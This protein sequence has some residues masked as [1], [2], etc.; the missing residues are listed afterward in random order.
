[1][2]IAS[3]IIGPIAGPVLGSAL[4]VSLVGHGVSWGVNHFEFADMQKQRDAADERARVSARS[5]DTCIV[6]LATIDTKL[7][8]NTSQIRAW[9][10]AGEDST[11]R[12]QEA[13]ETVHKAVAATRAAVAKLQSAPRVAPIGSFEACKA[14]IAAVRGDVP[15]M[16]RRDVP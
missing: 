15:A 16:R 1:M 7:D 3:W 13:Q 9:Q 10:K 5:G 11:K 8:E 12:A 2:S 14:G 4:A 6:N